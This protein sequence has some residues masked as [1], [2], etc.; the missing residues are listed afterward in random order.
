[1]PHFVADELRRRG[2]PVRHLH[3]WDDYDRFRKVPRGVDPSYA[4]H[5]GRP[6]VAVPDP[7]GCHD[8]WSTHFKEPVL[9]A[10]AALGRRGRHDLPGRALPLGR[11]PRRGAARRPP[12]RGD[13]RRARPSTAPR[14]PTSRSP[15]RRARGPGGR[16]DGR[17]G[18][19]R[20]PGHRRRR[21]RRRLLPVQALLPRLRPRHDHG[22]GVRRRHHRPRLRVLGVRLPRHHQPRD[23]GRGQARLEGRLADALGLRAR[24]LRAGR[25]GPRDARVVV[26]GRA[27][28]GRVGV[29]L[30]APGLVRLRLRRLRGRPEDVVVG[31][32]RP[33]GPGRPAGARAGHPAVAL[34]PAPAEADLRHRLRARGRAAVRR[35]GR[36]GPE[37]RRPRQARRAGARLRACLGDRDRRTAAGAPGRRTVPDAGVGGRRDRGLRRADQPDRLPPRPRPRLGRRPGAAPVAGG[38]VDRGV[39]AGVRPHDGARG[40]RHRA[41]GGADRSGARVARRS[42]SRGSAPATS[43]WSR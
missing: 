34:R 23:A 32:R 29:G 35:V 6:L 4:E 27:R 14:S 31:R 3:V 10:F 7:W 28:A 42:C 1:M 12:P 8:S 24:R 21:D 36:A 5:I 40:A 19:A 18:R 9:E 43:T 11:L 33:D 41:A 13:R 17:L 26:H 20:R 15:R 2:V 30:P 37:G 22:H 16:G 38:V 39:R 25:D